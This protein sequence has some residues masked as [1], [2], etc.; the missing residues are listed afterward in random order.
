MSAGATQLGQGI[1]EYSA[2][3][4]TQR[5]LVERRRAGEL[6]DL[7]WLL[8][9]PPTVTWGSSGGLDH[10][11]STEEELARSGIALVA[12]ERG[13]DVT[14]HE[15]GQL[16]GYAI[17]DIGIDKDLHGHLRRL[18]EGLIACLAGLGLESFRVPGRT[19]VWIGDAPRKIAA[20]GVRA[21]GWITSHGFALN[22]KNKLGGFDHIV[23]CGIRG[24]GVTSLARE[25]GEDRLPTWAELS[26]NVH[27]SL[28][29]ALGRRL[30][31]VQGRG[32]LV[33]AG[34]ES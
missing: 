24:A 18:E 31:L 15:P 1:V 10:V 20:I 22:V 8:E 16:V 29:A 9:H 2:A 3:Q 30:D 13:G 26:R 34:T 6:P 12:S 4:A 25:L 32:G 33:L 27:A 11:L 17:V 19:G 23:P 14:A 21:K 28:E 5:I 7:L